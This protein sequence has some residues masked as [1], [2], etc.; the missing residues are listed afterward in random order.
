M[1][2]GGG[3][4]G[5]G[6]VG[7]DGSVSAV[8]AGAGGS[9][10]GP[11]L[12]P[13]AAALHA[14]EAAEPAALAEPI[15]WQRGQLLGSGSFGS[16]FFGLNTRSGALPTPPA[17]PPPPSLWPEPWPATAALALTSASLAPRPSP[18]ARRTL[19]LT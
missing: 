1:G 4:G 10:P 16:V 18:L 13:A 12:H 8:E 19:R 9:V 14:L 7:G 17:R 11:A 6:S 3:G 5:E 15:S 2:S